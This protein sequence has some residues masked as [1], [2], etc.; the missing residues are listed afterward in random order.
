MKNIRNPVVIHTHIAF[1]VDERPII[2]RANATTVHTIPNVVRI[3]TTNY[4]AVVLEK[5]VD[6][7]NV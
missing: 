5:I 6:C 7:S 2:K 4:L 1:P 3:A